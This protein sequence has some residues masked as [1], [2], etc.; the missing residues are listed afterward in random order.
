MYWNTPSS[1][2]SWNYLSNEPSYA[3]NEF[4]TRVLCLFYSGGAICPRLISDHATLNVSAISPCTGVQN[5]WYLMRWK[6][7]LKEHLK[8][9][10]SLIVHLWTRA[11]ISME[12][13]TSFSSLVDG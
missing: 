3:L 2:S 10:F 12:T 5:W 13:M 1:W 4:R 7:G 6:E 11:Q 9:N 8:I